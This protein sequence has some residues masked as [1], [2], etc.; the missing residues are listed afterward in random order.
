[1]EITVAKFRPS[2]ATF[3]ISNT[4]I[5]ERRVSFFPHGR[6]HCIVSVDILIHIAV[7]FDPGHL[8]VEVALTENGIKCLRLDQTSKGSNA[9][10]KFRNNPENLV[11]LL[12]GYALTLFPLSFDAQA[13]PK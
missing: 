2:C 10:Q 7:T 11:L 4:P 5:L 8:V 13:I 9:I 3:V 6:I 1:L 12:D